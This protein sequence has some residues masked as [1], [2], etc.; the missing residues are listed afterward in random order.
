MDALSAKIS[1]NLALLISGDPSLWDMVQT[2]F[3]VSLLAIVC[4]TPPALAL[5]FVLTY[6]RFPG[7][8]L[9]VSLFHALLAVPAIVIGMTI[10]LLLSHSG[11]LGDLQLLFTRPAMIAGQMLLGF[12]IVVAVAHSALK[13]ADS[14]AWE[15]ART[16]GASPPRTVLT[17]LYEVRFGL[18]TAL[19]L[20]FGRV[21]GEVGCAMV[22]GGN[23]LQHTRSVS[24]ATALEASK[25]EF[26][27]GI[28]L[29][30]VLLLL[31]FLLVLGL[32]ALQDRLEQA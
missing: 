32:N 12:P 26:T 18:F 15:T 9:L 28:A 4:I 8:R 3:T 2:S 10:Y 21:I 27:Q 31:A 16:L 25:G 30:V 1:A 24:T 13:G 22:V 6:L 7:R 14:S 23:I 17:V 19:L 29:G 5:A 11:P 20:A